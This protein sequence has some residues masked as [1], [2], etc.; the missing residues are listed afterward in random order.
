MEALQPAIDAGLLAEAGDA[1]NKYM[2]FSHEQVRAF[3]LEGL[4]ATRRRA[5]HSA[6]IDLLTADGEPGPEVLPMV[7]RQALAAGDTE[8]TARY[9]LDAAREALRTS[10]PDEALR[11]VEDALAVVSHPSQRVELLRIRDDALQSLGRSSDRLDSLAELTALAEAVGNQALEFDVQLRRAAALRAD[12]RFDAAADIA[13][14]VRAK[15][16]DTELA[17][18][19][20]ACLE[21]GQDLLRSPLGE[22]YT[23]TPLESDFD[24]AQEA[25]ERALVLA[26]E[27]G[28]EIGQ[29]VV[30][31]ELGVIE[32]ARIRE[33]FVERVKAGEHIPFVIRI[34]NGEPLDQISKE[35]PI[36]GQMFHTD[37]L[38]TRSLELFEKLATD[39]GRCP[40]S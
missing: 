11:L 23:P 25:F 19:L 27:S 29:A 31:R 6:V 12:G 9:S 38:L 2:T 15:A 10:A 30:L 39:V 8:R 37:Q 32:L 40:R 28:S 5:M 36:Y 20:S 33:W 14:K 3:A 1:A 4:P 7:V 17:D 16:A 35:L 18:E 24:G 21:L 34:A 22:G 13:R 26:E